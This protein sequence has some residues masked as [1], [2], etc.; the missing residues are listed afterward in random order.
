MTESFSVQKSLQLHK[1]T[2]SSKYRF[3][4]MSPLI[5]LFVDISN[6]IKSTNYRKNSH[7]LTINKPKQQQPC[8][9]SRYVQINTHAEKRT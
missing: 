3:P 4:R 5:F 9:E 8:V 1:K 2:H 6:N 7:L